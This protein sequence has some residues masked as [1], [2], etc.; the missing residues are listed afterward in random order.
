MGSAAGE[1]EDMPRS[2]EVGDTVKGK[3]ENAKGIGKASGGQPRET[4]KRNGLE[5]GAGGEDN[6]PALKEIDQH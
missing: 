5:Q 2:M 3:E 6:E 4:V 1:N